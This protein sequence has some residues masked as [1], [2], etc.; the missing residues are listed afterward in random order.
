[1]RSGTILIVDTNIISD[2]YIAS[3]EI[4]LR[5]LAL[6]CTFMCD[7]VKHS[8]INSST[9]DEHIHPKIRT[10]KLSAK[11]NKEISELSQNTGK[12]SIYDLANFVVCKKRGYTLVTGDKNLREYSRRDGIDV[13]GVL[14]VL[15]F[16]LD[17]KLIKISEYKNALNHLKLSEKTRLPIKKINELLVQIENI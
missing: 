3:E 5:F 15:E 13:I 1:M 6:E 4:L 11:E 16:M 9:C 12:L 17:K 2:L 14:G 10:L 7:I 8:E